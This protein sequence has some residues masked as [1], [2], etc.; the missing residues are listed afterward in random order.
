MLP[1]IDVTTFGATG[2]GT[3]DDTA[4]INSAINACVVT[5]TAPH[6]GCILY[7]PPG[8]YEETGITLPAF[9]SA[10]G[11][12]WGISVLQ[13][14]AGTSADVITITPSTFNFSLYGLT[15]DGNSAN[16]GTGNCFT[17]QTSPI[18]PEEWNTANKQTAASNS[19]RWGHIEE[20]MFSNCSQ[21]GVHINVYNYAMFFTNF[22]IFNNGVYGLWT[23]GTNSHFMNCII[24]RNGTS[25]V[26]ITNSNNKLTSCAVI[27]NGNTDNTQ[28]A[29][30]VAGGRN[31]ITAVDTED[32]YTSGFYDSGP[33]NQFIGD[34]SD[35]NGY[36]HN[37]AN[38]SSL[39]ASGFVITGQHSV[40][41]GCKVTSYRGLL[42]D[43]NYTTEWPYTYV[44]SAVADKVDITFDGVN[45]QPP[46]VAADLQV[47]AN[48]VVIPSVGTASSAATDAN[49]G[50]LLFRGSWW[51]GSISSFSDWTIQ[52]QLN[53]TFDQLVFTPPIPS[54]NPGSPAVTFPQQ[55]TATSTSG[56]YSSVQLKLSSSVWNGTAPAFPGWLM[57]STVG[58]GTNPDNV[59]TLLPF[60][61]TGTPQIN[62]NANTNNL[63]PWRSQG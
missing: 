18:S 25:G 33:D 36:A 32:N 6:N 49:S 22:Y 45:E 15:L 61:S 46:I 8:I 5:R 50:P 44:G 30:H 11:A 13:L 41:I 31:T 24:E 9:V 58:T 3:T 60:N 37:N 29:V 57:Q 55:L 43:G 56:N 27:W 20:M 7:F 52:H 16:G 26:F 54:T 38:A 28:A 21:D 35:S 17:V 47:Y 14:K 34:L 12:G 2:D 53:S 40:F 19:S 1:A 4:A 42:G 48:T 62:L 23:Q 10:Q 39:G 51:N 59:F 63:G